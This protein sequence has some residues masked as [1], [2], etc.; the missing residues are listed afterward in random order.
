MNEVLE[1]IK[2]RRSI[3]RYKP[4]MVE[5]DKIEQIVVAGLYAASGMNKQS[6]K[7]I[8]VKNKAFR[9]KLSAEKAKFDGWRDGDDPF[10]GAPV[11]LIVLTEKSQGTYVYDG[12]LVMGNLMLAAH[13]VGLGSCWV[14]RAKEFF[15]QPE[16]QKFLKS[17]GIEGDWE[18][19]GYCI[20]G[21]IDGKPQKAPKRKENR[22]YYID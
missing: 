15:E 10:Y 9:D 2:N 18:G 21:Y 12:S 3:R 13:A 6:T 7:I 22:V 17:L 14:C 5:Q 1:A 8:V 19:V 4:D 16:Y 11:I 20:L